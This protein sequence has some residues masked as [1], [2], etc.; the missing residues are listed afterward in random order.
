LPQTTINTDKADVE[1]PANTGVVSADGSWNGV[2]KV[3]TITEVS[4]PVAAGYNTISGTAIEVGYSGAKLTFNNAVKITMAGQHG[5]MVGYTRDGE[6]FTEITFICAENSQDWA[7]EN[8]GDE[9]EEC[10]YDNGTDLIIWTKH[11]TKFA[12]YTQVAKTSSGGGGGYT[13][14]CTSVT[15]GEWGGTFN[16]FQ[17]RSIINQAPYGCYFTDVQKAAMVRPVEVITGSSAST[18]KSVIESSDKQVLGVKTYA[19]GTLIRSITTKRIYVVTG[20]KSIQHITSLKELV[21]YRGKAILSVD[22]SVIA[23]YSQVLGV[24]KFTDGTLVR[25]HGDHKIYIYING[26]KVHIKT[27]KDLAKYAGQPIIEIE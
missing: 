20:E 16:G 11:F 22:E 17:Y 1:I 8:L 13:A 7:D 10:K 27:L 4:L 6:G 19:I 26:V 3:P 23:S 15:Y 9:H 24:K 2:M 25:S 18:T 14:S 21:K 12:T 5:K